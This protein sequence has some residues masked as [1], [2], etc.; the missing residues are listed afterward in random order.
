MLTNDI[1]NA[2]NT[3][4]TNMTEIAGNVTMAANSPPSDSTGAIVGGVVGGA[5]GLLLLVAVIFG[6]RRR[7]SEQELLK[8]QSGVVS[9]RGQHQMGVVQSHITSST[10]SSY[11]D[12]NLPEQAP[13]NGTHYQSFDRVYNY[14]DVNTGVVYDTAL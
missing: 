4:S 1:A 2:N 3:L 8:G 5:V 11:A 10:D 13:P 6:V 12:G 7:R 14:G 9:N